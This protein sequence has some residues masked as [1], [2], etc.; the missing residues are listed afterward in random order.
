MNEWLRLTCCAPLFA[1]FFAV[2]TGFTALE[3]PSPKIWRVEAARESS[4][5]DT[6]SKTG[7]VSAADGEFLKK[8]SYKMLRTRARIARMSHTGDDGLKLLE[9]AYEQ[10]DR[11]PESMKHLASLYQKAGKTQKAER[12]YGQIL[13][14]ADD[15]MTIAD[16][17]AIESERKGEGLVQGIRRYLDKADAKKLEQMSAEFRQRG[18]YAALPPET[19]LFMTGVYMKTGGEPERV[20]ALL[21]SAARSPRGQKLL[22]PYIGKKQD[23]GMSFDLARLYLDLSGAQMKPVAQGIDREKLNDLIREME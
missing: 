19:A 8:R 20:A 7:T 18:K 13:S 9:W 16:A 21:G 22:E 4:I 10:G 6:L 23:G 11:D 15:P 5:V 12:I 17:I 3:A 2:L 14:T 1:A